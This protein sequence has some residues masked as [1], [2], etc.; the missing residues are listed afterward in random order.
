MHLLY[1]FSFF[2]CAGGELGLSVEKSVNN[3]AESIEM[4]RFNNALRRIVQI[5]K[6]ELTWLLDEERRSKT[7]KTKP[8]PKP[9]FSSSVPA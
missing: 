7:G 2:L 8:G 6:S 4:S 9:R 1:Q 3:P 5:Q